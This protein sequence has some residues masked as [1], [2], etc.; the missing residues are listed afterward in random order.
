MS[1][2]RADQRWRETATRRASIGGGG[3]S[4]AQPI[5]TRRAAAY[6]Q[7]AQQLSQTAAHEWRDDVRRHMLAVSNRQ[8]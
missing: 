1:H 3:N 7:R 2:H 8:L 6:R 5:A 4:M